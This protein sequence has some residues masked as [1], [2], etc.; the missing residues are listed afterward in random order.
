M[1]K[2]NT[3]ILKL[4]SEQKRMHYSPPQMLNS[5]LH[6]GESQVCHHLF[7]EPPLQYIVNQSGS[8]KENFSLKIGEN[9]EMLVCFICVGAQDRTLID[10]NHHYQIAMNQHKN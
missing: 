1:L 3:S 7:Y 6:K 4:F 10:N 9:I 2:Q 5:Y 8:T